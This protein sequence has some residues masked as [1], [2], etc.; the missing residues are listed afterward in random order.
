[1]IALVEGVAKAIEIAVGMSVVPDE[2]GMHA[3][4]ARAMVLA[5]INIDGMRVERRS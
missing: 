1:M 3:A 2:K 5:I 4:N